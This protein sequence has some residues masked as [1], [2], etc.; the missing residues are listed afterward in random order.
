MDILW[1]SDKALAGSDF[2]FYDKTLSKH[3][4]CMNLKV[5]LGLGLVEVKE[6]VLRKR[7][8]TRMYVPTLTE[9]EYETDK[10][11]DTLD[12]KKFDEKMIMSYLKKNSKK[13]REKLEKFADMINQGLLDE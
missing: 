12:I 3:V 13:E 1:K 6:T 2:T 8:K 9:K 11:F 4:A 10:L 7:A 5:L